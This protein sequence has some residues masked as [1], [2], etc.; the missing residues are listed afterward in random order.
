MTGR[1]RSAAVD[2]AIMRATFELSEQY[3]YRGVTMERIA[4]HSGVAKQTIYRRYR[5]KGEVFLDALATYAAERLPHPDT[6]T[7]YGDLHALLSATF[8]AQQG[9]S[10]MLNRA[11][12]TE[13]LQDDE[14]AR[15]LWERLI[16]KRRG[17][18]R[19]IVDRARARGEVRRAD[20][21]FLVDLV[22]G[23]MWYW[24]LFGR[25]HLGPGYAAQIAGAVATLAATSG[26]HGVQ[27][28]VDMQPLAGGGG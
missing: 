12:A 26:D 2:D 24:L 20:D 28:A 13:A 14:F 6:G 22:F 15:L 11:L 9:A 5:S 16:D 18:V 19:D 17:A 21:D 8:D 7:L 27:P 10:G 1:P 23:P 3:G 25:S 4:S